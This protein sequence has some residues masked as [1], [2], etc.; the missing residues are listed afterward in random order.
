M[1]LALPKFLLRNP[2]PIICHPPK[3][4][5]LPPTAVPLK[6]QSKNP[7]TFPLRPPPPRPSIIKRPH[8]RNSLPTFIRRPHPLRYELR[9]IHSR[10][11]ESTVACADHLGGE[12]RVGGGKGA[13]RGFAPACRR[14]LV[15]CILPWL[16]LGI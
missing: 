6:S 4:S 13:E 5:R 1:A 14:G 12:I 8:R 9:P 15:V 7:P 2:P 16:F 3:I 11:Q 10:F